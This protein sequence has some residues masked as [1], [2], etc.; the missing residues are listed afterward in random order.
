MNEST[1]T[2]IATAVASILVIVAGFLVYNYFSAISTTA[3]N[4]PTRQVSSKG[5]CD[6]FYGWVRVIKD[7][8]RGVVCWVISN[9]GIYCI[10]ENQLGGDTE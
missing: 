3:N 5:L 7:E 2:N 10:P 6:D 1:K 8:E 4:P 9:E